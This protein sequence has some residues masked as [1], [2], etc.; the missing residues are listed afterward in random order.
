MIPLRDDVPCPLVPRVVRA[1]LA[2]NVLGYLVQLAAGPGF[3]ERFALR[4]AVLVGWW[5][6]EPVRIIQEVVGA[7][8]RQVELAREWVPGFVESALPLLTSQFLHGDALHLASNLLFLW[9]FADNVEGEL[10]HRWFLAFYLGCGVLAGLAHALFEPSSAVPTIGASGAIAG[11]LG[12]YFVRF[13][14]ARVLTLVPV[15]FIPV[16]LEVPAVVFLGLWFALQVLFGIAGSAGQLA[17][18]AHVG[19]FVA[20]LALVGVLPRVMHRGPRPRYRIDRVE[21]IA[22]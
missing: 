22:R 5:H 19:G 9:I 11:V 8:G 21:R 18:W 10:G 14:H 16:L 12:A 2:L 13:P 6:G 3:T 15:L 4:P 7:G 1:L 17:V 20:G